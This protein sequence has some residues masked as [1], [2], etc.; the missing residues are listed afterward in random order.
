MWNLYNRIQ[1]SQIILLVTFYLTLVGYSAYAD[2]G[3]KSTANPNPTVNELMQS[4]DEFRGYKDQGFQFKIRNISYRG[5][6]DPR[7]NSLSIQV[8]NEQSLVRFEAPV[9]EKGRAMLK[10]GDNIW[11]YIP[12]TRKVIRVAPSQRLLGEASNADVVGTNF[13]QDYNGKVLGEVKVDGQSLW[14]LELSANSISAPYA[15]V[16]VW[17]ESAP[18][19]KPNKSEFYTRSGK[20]LKTAFYKEFKHYDGQEKVHK[21]LL[22]DAVMKENYTWMKFDDYEKVELQPAQFQKSAL[23]QAVLK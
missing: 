6:R 20:L 5:N 17:L 21:L 9:R 7:E 11:L 16:K 19:Y 18:P 12:G 13:T 22:V 10:E 14:L 8:L 1:Y 2:E 15:R 3:L 4:L 23:T